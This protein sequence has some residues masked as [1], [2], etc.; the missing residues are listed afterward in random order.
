VEDEGVTILEEA[1]IGVTEGE[2]KESMARTEDAETGAG[3]GETETKDKGEV[4]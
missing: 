3:G 2:E 1:G 4:S